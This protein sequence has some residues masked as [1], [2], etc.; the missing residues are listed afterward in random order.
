MLAP[1]V[2]VLLLL[3]LLLKVVELT[4]Y[5]QIPLLILMVGAMIYGMPGFVAATRSPV[6]AVAAAVPRAHNAAGA[7]EFVAVAGV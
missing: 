4:S 1:L 5:Y 2:V 3:L 7:E 6:E